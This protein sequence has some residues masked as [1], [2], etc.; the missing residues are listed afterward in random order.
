MNAI[1]IRSAKPE[2]AAEIQRIY[3]YYVENTAISFEYDIPSEYKTMS[4]IQ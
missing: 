1:I 4:G 2:D 3:G